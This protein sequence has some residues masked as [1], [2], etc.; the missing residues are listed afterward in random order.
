VT[1]LIN[2][3]DDIPPTA[4]NPLPI[5][6]AGCNMPLPLPDVSVVID[7]ADNCTAAPVVAFVND[8]SSLVGCIETTTR[9]Y[10][11]TDDCGNSILVA[12]T[13]TRTVDTEP[14]VLN[15][16]A[17]LTVD[18]LAEVPPITN[19]TYTD[20]CSGGGTVTGTQTG[21]SGSP[22]TIVYTWTVTDNCGNTTTESQTI[23]I[24]EILIP[25]SVSADFCEGG[26]VDVYGVT[27]DIPGITRTLFRA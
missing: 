14:P 5:N 6:V 8:A 11:V 24:L 26:S 2:V 13:I 3:G 10:S 22:L 16:P 9:N 25:L 20:N 23:T 15:P 17:D 7:E 4:S 27:Y 12:Q 19:L 18:C 1:Q 21:P